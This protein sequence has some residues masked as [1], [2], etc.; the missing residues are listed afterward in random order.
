MP[1]RLRCADTETR[2]GRPSG[3]SETGTNVSAQV[4]VGHNVDEADGEAIVEFRE[5]R[6][7]E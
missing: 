6:S 3:E 5:R 4:R 1:L 7:V 2:K